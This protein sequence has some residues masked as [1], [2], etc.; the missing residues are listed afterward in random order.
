MTGTA[1]S[2][3]GAGDEAASAVATVPQGVH[4]SN[5]LGGDAGSPLEMK[6]PFIPILS[7]LSSFSSQ[8]VKIRASL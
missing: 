7:F 5:L 2:W 4:A 8:P 3:P 6:E 1:L